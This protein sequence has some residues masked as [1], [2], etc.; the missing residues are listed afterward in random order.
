MVGRPPEDSQ[1]DLSTFTALMGLAL[2]AAALTFMAALVVPQVLGI[3]LV[4]CGFGGMFVLHYVT[5]GWW[6]S[7]LPPPDE[8]T[9]D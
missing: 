4:V 5:W 8:P 3:V 9:D 7:R 2:I 1:R 6:L